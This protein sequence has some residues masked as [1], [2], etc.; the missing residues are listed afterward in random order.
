MKTALSPAATRRAA[1]LAG[2]VAV[3]ALVYFALVRPVAERHR[4][5]DERHANL[6][7]RLATFQRLIAEGAE[8]RRALEERRLADPARLRYLRERNPALAAVELQDLVKRAVSAGR[9]ELISTQVLG[10]RLVDA[11]GEITVKVRL[12]GSTQTLQ[13]TL[14]A[15]ESGSPML[16]V[17]HLS[18]DSSEGDLV[19]GFDITGYSRAREL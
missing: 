18:I 9:G 13:R 11:R 4:A 7:Q 14:H 12:R 10:G 6:I 16:F 2:V 5:Y 8:A 1:A 19:I 15:L 3:M 17:D